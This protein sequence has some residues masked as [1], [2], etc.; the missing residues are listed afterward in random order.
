MNSVSE[1][2]EKKSKNLNPSLSLFSLPDDILLNCI[3]RISPSYYPKLTLVSKTFASLVSSYELYTTR[4]LQKTDEHILYVYLQFS[5]YSSSPLSWFCL[6]LKP[7][8]TLTNDLENT[9]NALLV[10]IPSSYCQ[11]L[12]A[13]TCKV[14]SEWYAINRYGYPASNLSVSKSGIC[15]WLELPNMTVARG[16]DAI[17]GVLDAKIYVMGGCSIYETKNWAEVYDTKTQTWES[18]PDPGVQL[19]FSTLK[20]MRV[21]GEK[22]YVESIKRNKNGCDVYD[23]KEGRW[24]VLGRPPMIAS[25]VVIEN[26][27]YFYFNK[28][29]LWYD[30]KHNKWGRVKGLSV[31]KR[32]CE[33]DSGSFEVVNC[34]GKLLMIWD[35]LVHACHGYEKNIWCASIAFKKGNGDENVRGK[36]EWANSVRTVPIS[37]V[38]VRHAIRSL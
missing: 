29:I 16:E 21:K 9:G 2:S 23:T 20:K 35:K 22:I 24:K 38:L 4:L 5:S 13:F 12:P 10:P 34:G 18:L 17:A 37:C 14:G 1:P 15:D 6:W 36:V 11:R 27:R 8:Q 32:Y 19:R 3:A 7:N 26:I 31:L 30:K 25:N 28:G 33:G